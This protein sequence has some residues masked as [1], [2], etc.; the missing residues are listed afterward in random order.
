[1]ILSKIFRKATKGANTF[2]TRNQADMTEVSDM[3]RE[4]ISTLA[5]LEKAAN[6]YAEQ[7][8]KATKELGYSIKEYKEA[9]NA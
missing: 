4:K 3:A 8:E 6:D 1:M 5:N 9:S 2:K 7:L